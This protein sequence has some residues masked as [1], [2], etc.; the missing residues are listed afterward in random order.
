MPPWGITYLNVCT[1]HLYHKQ[2]VSKASEHSIHPCFAW[3]TELCALNSFHF[4]FLFWKNK[5]KQ[6]GYDPLNWFHDP[7]IGHNLQVENYWSSLLCFLKKQRNVLTFQS[8]TFSQQP[9]SWR[10]LVLTTSPAPRWVCG[11]QKTM[12]TYQD[13]CWFEIMREKLNSNSC[14]EPQILQRLIHIPSASPPAS[15]S[16]SWVPFSK[17]YTAQHCLSSSLM[18]FRQQ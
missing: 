1:F 3:G 17:S 16:L 2:N 7:L 10:T 8:N 14:S 18:L 9:A 13:G 12:L 6:P 5:T 15:L 4:P 11:A